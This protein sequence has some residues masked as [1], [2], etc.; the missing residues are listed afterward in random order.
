[1]LAVALECCLRQRQPSPAP[2]GERDLP[3]LLCSVSAGHSSPG[4]TARLHSWRGSGLLHCCRLGEWT[5]LTPPM[6][7]HTKAGQISSHVLPPN[8]AMLSLP[9]SILLS[10]QILF[11]NSSPRYLPLIFPCRF[12]FLLTC[13]TNVH[14]N[15]TLE[16]KYWS[17][18]THQGECLPTLLSLLIQQ[19]VII[20]MIH[21]TSKIRPVTY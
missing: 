12:W 16:H 3:G 11:I 2:G 13:S 4:L 21:K 9:S 1:M 14:P 20:T 19:H 7:K 18:W 6:V 5:A 17:A 15:P 8:H 10:F